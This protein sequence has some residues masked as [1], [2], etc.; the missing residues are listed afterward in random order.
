MPT[1][2][3]QLCT[4]MKTY[5]HGHPTGRGN[6]FPGPSHHCRNRRSPFAHQRIKAAQDCSR[7][8]VKTIPGR[9]SDPAQTSFAKA[10]PKPPGHTGGRSRILRGAN[11]ALRLPHLGAQERRGSQPGLTARASGAT[12][13][14]FPARANPQGR[15]D[16]GRPAVLRS[17]CV[18]LSR[19]SLA[20]CPAP[21][22]AKA[23]DFCR[24][25]S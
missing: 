11:A 6:G 16:S 7:S 3:A 17:R 24:A 13:H 22:L 25:A 14:G 15:D 5:A 10:R 19:A 20:P 8:A 23:Q 9:A 18:C 1:C 21:R 12:P 2:M 4:R